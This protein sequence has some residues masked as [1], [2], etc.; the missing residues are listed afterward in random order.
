MKQ[1]TASPAYLKRQHLV[2]SEPGH[3][4]N[5]VHLLDHSAPQAEGAPGRADG[6]LERDELAEVGPVSVKSEPFDSLGD[7]RPAILRFKSHRGRR[8]MLL[9]L[10]VALLLGPNLYWDDAEPTGKRGSA[11]RPD[12]PPAGI[13]PDLTLRPR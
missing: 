4:Q 10:L 11:L 13:A 5:R 7:L 12:A 9:R 3:A 6:R 1:F 8:E 2:A